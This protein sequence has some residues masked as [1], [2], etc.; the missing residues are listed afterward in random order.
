MTYD[1]R[2]LVRKGLLERLPHRHRY[3]L[4]EQGAD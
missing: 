2:R 4:T 1:L 3:P